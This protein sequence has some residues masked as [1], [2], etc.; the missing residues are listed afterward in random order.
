MADSSSAPMVRTDEPEWLTPADCAA[1]LKVDARTI[2][3]LCSPKAGAN[4][5]VAARIGR[6]LRIRKSV[7]ELWLRRAEKSA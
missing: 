6:Q 1:L 2:Q 3:R 4:R 5:I 7:L